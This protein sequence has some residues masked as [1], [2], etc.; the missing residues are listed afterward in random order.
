[1]N[2]T[3]AFNRIAVVQRGH[4]RTWKYI[5]NIVKDF[6]SNLAHEVDYYFI[7]WD[8]EQTRNYDVSLDFNTGELIQYQLVPIP[9]NKDSI[10]SLYNGWR[11]PSHLAQMAI[12]EISKR[13]YDLVIE[14]RPDIIPVR[15]YYHVPIVPSYKD[16]YTTAFSVYSLDGNRPSKNNVC[17]DDWTLI[18]HPD[19]YQEIAERAI[20]RPD[21]GLYG[22]QRVLGEYIQ[23]CGMKIWRTK[24]MRSYFTRPNSIEHLPLINFRD[25]WWETQYGRPAASCDRLATFY[26]EWGDLSNET[27]MNLLNQYGFSKEDWRNEFHWRYD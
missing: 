13:K 16:Y 27:K 15:N 26:R 9:E 1:M 6:Y 7:L 10:D 21:G 19:R 12:P 23:S 20:K 5:K 14:T 8:Y 18:M 3:I 11:G 22:H 24:W 17:L 2:R 25:G 4:L